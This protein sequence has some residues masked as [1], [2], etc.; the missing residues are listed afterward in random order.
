MHVVA[1]CA[2]NVDG[3]GQMLTDL[4]NTGKLIRL[5]IQSVT[6]TDA[7]A[8]AALGKAVAAYKQKVPAAQ[9]YGI[10]FGSVIESASNAGLWT[11]GYNRKVTYA[12]C[13]NALK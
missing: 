5:T 3:F 4:K 6:G 13:A 11:T 8:A 2:Y 12:S 7:Q 9:Q 10:T 1:V